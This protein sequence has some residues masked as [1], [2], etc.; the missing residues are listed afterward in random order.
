MRFERKI[1]L[2]GG[3]CSGRELQRGKLGK[4]EHERR[5]G[6]DGGWRIDGGDQRGGGRRLLD[7]HKGI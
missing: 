4:H 2:R 6:R 7:W 1:Y 3:Q 5:G